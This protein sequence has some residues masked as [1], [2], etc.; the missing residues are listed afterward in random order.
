LNVASIITPV[1]SLRFAVASR[2]APNARAVSLESRLVG[3]PV[4]GSGL[5]ELPCSSGSRAEEVD[6]R[7]NAFGAVSV[8]HKLGLDRNGATRI[9]VLDAVH[10]LI[11]GDGGG[12]MARPLEVLIA[13]AAELLHRDLQNAYLRAFSNYLQLRCPDDGPGCNDYVCI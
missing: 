10:S 11:A 7:G 13:E 6:G 3:L 9:E 8:L 2:R 5:C 4:A 12:E 1:R